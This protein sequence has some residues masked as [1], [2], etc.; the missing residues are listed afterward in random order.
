MNP[1]SQLT[2]LRKNVQQKTCQGFLCLSLLRPL[3][4]QIQTIAEEQRLCN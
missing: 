3:Q 4:V 2:F 1:Q